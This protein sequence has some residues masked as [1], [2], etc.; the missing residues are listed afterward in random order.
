MPP[1]QTLEQFDFH[2]RLEATPGTALVVF[3]APACGAC[4]ALKR[5][6][7]GAGEVLSGVTVFEVDAQRDMG[8]V[9]EFEVFHLPSL[10]LY[11]EGRFHCQLQ[12]R[13]EARDLARAIAQAL[14]H[15]PQEQP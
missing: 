4:R 11:Q 2:H 3:S 13:A 8:L 6:L 10:F 12:A 1:I 15:A 5:E 14:Q 7:L 9:R